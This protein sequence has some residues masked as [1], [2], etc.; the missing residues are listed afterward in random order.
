MSSHIQVL[1]RKRGREHVK[2]NKSSL[3]GTQQVVCVRV[4]VACGAPVPIYK[5]ISRESS[6]M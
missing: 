5:S 3:P 4:C 1:S 2:A 6:L